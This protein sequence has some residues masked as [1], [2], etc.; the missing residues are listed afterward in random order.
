MENQ[1][2]KLENKV[3]DAKLFKKNKKLKEN[4]LVD[5]IITGVVLLHKKADDGLKELS[6]MCCKKD[7]EEEIDGKREA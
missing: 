1:D 3:I 7:S 6:E 4:K 5:D 2:Q